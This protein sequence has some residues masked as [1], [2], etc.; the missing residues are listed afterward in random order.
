MK[1]ADA[2][3]RDSG[4]FRV[5]LPPPRRAALPARDTVA[6]QAFNGPANGAV[7]L[8]AVAARDVRGA[9][10]QLAPEHRQVITEIYFRGHSVAET[11]EILGIPSGTVNFLSYYAVRQIRRAITCPACSPPGRCLGGSDGSFQNCPR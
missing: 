9:L 8:G 11:A 6:G 3:G 7:R 10:A 1:T 2:V 4:P 5:I